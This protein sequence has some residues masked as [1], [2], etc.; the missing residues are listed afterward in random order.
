MSAARFARRRWLLAGLATLVVALA[1]APAALLLGFVPVDW[2]AAAIVHP[3]RKPLTRQPELPFEVVRFESGGERLEGWLFRPERTRGTVVYL[4]GIGDNRES[5]VGIARRLVSRG[6]AVLAFDA[7]AHGRST[8]ETCTYGYRERHD[9][10]RALDVLH[11][12]KAILLGHSLGAAVALQAAAV[13]PRVRAVVAASP[14]CDL[15]SIVAERAGWLLLPR[16]YAER[17]LARAGEIG[18]FPPDEASPVALAPA[19]RVPVL[20][21]HGARDRKTPPAHSLRIAAALPSPPVLRLL[22]SIGHDEILGRDE[23]WREIDAFL[24]GLSAP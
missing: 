19:V 14:F 4:H 18:G 6:Y 10:G 12:S 11:V 1:A 17:A 3:Y 16:S 21:L 2:G 5:G 23:A 7:R 24:A 8:G 9:V 22:P 15:R 20:L 13:D